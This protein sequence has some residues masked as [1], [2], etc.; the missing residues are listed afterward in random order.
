LD[1]KNKKKMQV[2]NA[3]YA[4]TELT[5]LSLVNGKSS[6][7]H[8]FDPSA[9][10]FTFADKFYVSNYALN[11]FNVDGSGYTRIIQ[12]TNAGGN[13]KYDEA[14]QRVYWQEEYGSR[15]VK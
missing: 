10:S 2:Q 3:F 8:A 11:T 1:G 4:P 14:S 7:C 13:I 15:Q 12:N 5:Q 6:K 9:S